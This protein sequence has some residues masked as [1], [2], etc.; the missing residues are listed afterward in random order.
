MSYFTEPYTH[1][2]NKSE[3]ELDLS[4]Y[5]KSDLKKRSRCWYIRCCKK[6]DLGTL[7]LDV[8]G[9]DI[10]KLKYVPSGLNSV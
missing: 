4:N 8:D 6:A 5:E 2:K 7:R 9:L 1:S 10:Y 3:V